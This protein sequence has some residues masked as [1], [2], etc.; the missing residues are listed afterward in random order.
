MG[1]YG[2]NV[3]HVQVVRGRAVKE[4]NEMATIRDGLLNRREVIGKMVL[5]AGAVGALDVQAADQNTPKA[6]QK[7]K[8][9]ESSVEVSPP[10]DLMREHA[11]LERLLLIY[12]KII[13]S[14]PLS[15]EWP[16]VQLLAAA[17]LVRS[18]VEDYH[19]KLEED[20][21]F[22]RFEKANKLPE[23]VTVLRIQHNVGRRLTDTILAFDVRPANVSTPDTVSLINAMQHFIRLYRPHAARESTVLFPQIAAVVGAEEYDK[24]GDRF[25]EIEHEKFGSQ[26]F[27]GIV[28]QVAAIEK[29]LGLYDLDQFT[30]PA[31]TGQ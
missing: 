15:K 12:E 7:P 16:S 17:K 6:G 31:V 5:A 27:E 20:H 26:G 4:V 11:V 24:L 18:F 3:D 10:E 19:E 23:L 22:P 8:T 2:E 21:L 9:Q 13:A 14:I 1:E 28:D 29:I 25:E 30:R